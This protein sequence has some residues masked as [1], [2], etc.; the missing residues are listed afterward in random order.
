MAPT[1]ASKRTAKQFTPQ[2]EIHKRA[3]SVHP[4][5]ESHGQA[6]TLLESND[7]DDDMTDTSDDEVDHDFV[8][9]ASKLNLSSVD[10][11]PAPAVERQVNLSPAIAPSPPV[12][13]DTVR[14]SRVDYPPATTQLEAIGLLA[15][16]G[17]TSAAVGGL[18]LPALNMLAHGM[19]PKEAVVVAETVADTSDA[20]PDSTMEY[21]PATTEVKAIILLSSVGVEP[22]AV[23]G[24]NLRALKLTIAS[25]L[26]RAQLDE[27]LSA[28]LT[29]K[30]PDVQVA[31][32]PSTISPASVAGNSTAALDDSA[33]V[34]T[35]SPQSAEASTA[36]ATDTIVE[37]YDSAKYYPPATTEAKAVALMS[38]VGVEPGA[39][40]GLGLA[41]LNAL[42]RVQLEERIA[43]GITPKDPT[44]IHV[45]G[46]IGDVRAVDV[47]ASGNALVKP[48][49]TATH[50]LSVAQAFLNSTARDVMGTISVLPERLL[51]WDIALMRRTYTIG[52]FVDHGRAV[53]TVDKVPV[54]ST[55]GPM[56]TFEDTSNFV[57]APNSSK[58]V[59]IFI[60][61]EVSNAYFFDLEGFPAKRAGLSGQPISSHI[62][63]FCKKQLNMLCMPRNSSVVA[64]AFGPDQVRVTCWMTSR[65]LKGQPSTT[66]EFTDFYD[67]RQTLKDKSL[68]QKLSI[69]SIK[70][71]DIVII[72]ARIARYAVQAPG[73]SSEKKGKKAM[74]RWQAFY[75]MQAVYLLKDAFDVP[76]PSVVADDSFN[77]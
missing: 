40:V 9:V 29:P 28:G 5:A 48:N 64:D 33:G 39:L 55:W 61:V 34:I 7:V 76:A 50:V 53:Y 58:P 10:D 49:A 62:Q 77:L 1:R 20:T 15:T 8:D 30:I 43:A 56:K 71:H 63:N 12:I 51:Y 26:Y 41:T 65:G 11:P 47:A 70:T 57:C 69:E 23:V 32:A 66:K 54:E 16:V 2:P 22:G 60:P 14:N 44:A 75:D 73:D 3:K 72:E 18:N 42:Y 4:A 31:S 74:T 21:P 13:F 24:L 68:M 17:V 27:M 6:S 37:V 19:I 38:T 45:G 59:S 35:G 36:F 67:A 25:A 52:T 46:S